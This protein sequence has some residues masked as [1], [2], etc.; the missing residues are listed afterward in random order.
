MQDGIESLRQRADPGGFCGHNICSSGRDER[1]F[2]MRATHMLPVQAKAAAHGLCLLPG[3]LETST[4]QRHRL[5]SPS[6]STSSCTWFLLSLQKGVPSISSSL[7]FKACVYAA[8]SWGSGNSKGS[9]WPS[10]Y[11]TSQCKQEWHGSRGQRRAAVDTVGR[12]TLSQCAKEAQS[13]KAG[14]ASSWPWLASPLLLAVLHSIQM[15]RQYAYAYACAAAG[16][17]CRFF[18]RNLPGCIVPRKVG[19]CASSGSFSSSDRVLLGLPGPTRSSNA[20]SQH[21]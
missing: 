4:S 10:A 14:A 19:I 1:A 3:R 13:E 8:L 18:G 2:P 12:R 15:L 6:A 11:I 7:S 5:C 9:T 16:V 21:A 20:R 17:V